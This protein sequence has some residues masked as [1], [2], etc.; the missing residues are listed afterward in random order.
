[1]TTG[2]SNKDLLDAV[3]SMKNRNKIQ[4]S[5]ISVDDWAKVP[6]E[7]TFV[8]QPQPHTKL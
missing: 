5:H 3:V 4:V 1:M 8:S 7:D 6:R 2:E